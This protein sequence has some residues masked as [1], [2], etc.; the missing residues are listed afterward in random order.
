[1]EEGSEETVDLMQALSS[2]ATKHQPVMV[3]ASAQALELHKNPNRWR[4]DVLF[5]NLAE[6][7]GPT[8]KENAFKIK[9]ID[10]VPIRT[11]QQAR[12]ISECVRKLDERIQRDNVDALGAVWI[13]MACLE[14]S[15][16]KP[17]WSVTPVLF[18]EAAIKSTKDG[19]P[20]K[21]ELMLHM[22]EGI[23]R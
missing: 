11:L 14:N 15:T 17:L 18:D 7:P 5:I 23:V 10:V 9:G 21:E 22:N 4:H 8:R 19:W 12:Q 16:G 20:W 1:M 6:R 2:Y 13:V 3:N